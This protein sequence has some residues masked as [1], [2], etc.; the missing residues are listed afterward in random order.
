L[1]YN[2]SFEKGMDQTKSQARSI[3]GKAFDAV[4]RLYA[5]HPTVENRTRALQRQADEIASFKASPKMA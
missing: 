1:K 5:T 4:N 2:L 3:F